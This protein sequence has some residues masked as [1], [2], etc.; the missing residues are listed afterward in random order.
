VFVFGGDVRSGI[1]ILPQSS[2]R[3]L[4]YYIRNQAVP[5]VGFAQSDHTNSTWKKWGHEKMGSSLRLTLSLPIAS[6]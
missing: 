1:N 3:T 6:I 2:Q 4:R 5:A